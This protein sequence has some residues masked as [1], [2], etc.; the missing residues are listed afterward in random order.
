VGRNLV[1]H[2][3]VPNIVVD[4]IPDAIPPAKD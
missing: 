4:F 3:I 2:D 1:L